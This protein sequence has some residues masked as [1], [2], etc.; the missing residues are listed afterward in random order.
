M[1]VYAYNTWRSRDVNVFLMFTQIRDIQ[2]Y[3]DRKLLSCVISENAT[4][5]VV[6]A[7]SLS[8]SIVV[9]PSPVKSENLAVIFIYYALS[10]LLPDLN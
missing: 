9:N 3:Q 7:L 1:I 6:C 4:P 10:Y 5:S 2:L 8:H